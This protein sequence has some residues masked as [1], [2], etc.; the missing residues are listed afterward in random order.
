MAKSPQQAIY[1]A[2]FQ[3][4]LTLGYKTYPYLPAKEATYPFVYVGEQF[5][6]DRNTKSV[7]YG[8][9]IQRIHIYHDYRK[10]S[11]LT[12]MMDDLKS[13]IRKLRRADGFAL[14]IKRINGQTLL[15]TS[16]TF[17]LYHGIVEVNITFN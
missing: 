14:N 6:N 5:D 15:D 11:E 2:I 13:E 7:I 1:D 8:G 9:V 3:A 17:P 16:T 12:G 4:S 10:R